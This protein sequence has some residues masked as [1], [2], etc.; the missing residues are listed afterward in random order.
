M[1]CTVPMVRSA[2]GSVLT[3]STGLGERIRRAGTHA[4][5][6]ARQPTANE[7]GAGVSGYPHSFAAGPRRAPP[8]SPPGLIPMVGQS[9]DRVQVLKVTRLVG[10]KDSIWIPTASAALA[11]L[12]RHRPSGR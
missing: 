5:P 9:T 4:G 8:A 12:V 1:L 6:V 3:A 10:A 7:R 11:A 2:T